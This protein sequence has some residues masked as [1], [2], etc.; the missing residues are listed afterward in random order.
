MIIYQILTT[1][2]TKDYTPA[3]FAETLGGIYTEA[4]GQGFFKHPTITTP[5]ALRD[6]L[7]QLKKEGFKIV[8]TT[9]TIYAKV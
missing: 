3:L 1:E 5:A 8:K 9:R 2:K 7:Q 6:H 4:P